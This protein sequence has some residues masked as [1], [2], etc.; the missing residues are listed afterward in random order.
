MRMTKKPHSNRIWI[1]LAALLIIVQ[2][3]GVS[4]AA[5]TSQGYLRGVAGNRDNDNIRFS[6]NYLA[7]CSTGQSD[8]TR[9]VLM[10]EKSETGD[11]N[12][13]IELFVY[14]Y[15]AG[16]KN[17]VNENDITYD[18]TITLSG[19]SASSYK[20]TYGD[21][22][23]SQTGSADGVLTYAKK[24]VTM[25]GRTPH[26]DRYTVTIP[27]KDL[28]KI[29]I[30]A[31][32]RPHNMV[33]TGNQFLAGILLP[34]TMSSVQT[35]SCTGRYA[36]AQSGHKPAEYDALNYEVLISS[37]RANVTLTWDAAKVEIDPYFLEKLKARESDT[38]Y[39]YDKAKGTLT[40]VMDQPAGEGDYVIPFYFVSS[41]TVPETWDALTQ[42]GMIKV[43]GEKIEEQ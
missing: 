3:V 10:Y 33:I 25:I 20:V 7:G 38:T 16:N 18:M 17:L 5:Y 42:S 31:V 8:Y 28:D 1:T 30:T 13:T 36:D 23:M 24:D 14:N 4:F 35:F 19:G 41:V 2:L 39:T 12:I 29:R 15:V 6:S 40:F 11:Q 34:S 26:E 21:T 27:E 9:K 37:G 43:T 22:A 32:A